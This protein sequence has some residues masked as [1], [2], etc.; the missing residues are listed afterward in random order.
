[1]AKLF[2]DHSPLI[3]SRFI[4]QAVKSILEKFNLVTRQEFETQTQVLL[5]TRAKL[6]QL[7]AK[8]NAFENTNKK[9]L[10]NKLSD[11]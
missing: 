4:E 8:L 2:S 7:E 9:R 10:T 3:P 5:K 6:E 11:I 1:M